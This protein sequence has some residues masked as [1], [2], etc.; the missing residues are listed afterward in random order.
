M[1]VYSISW[2][3]QYV[4]LVL[5]VTI[6]TLVQPCTQVA[7]KSVT[8]ASAS[9]PCVQA[10]CTIVLHD[11]FT[12][13][14]AAK[15]TCIIILTHQLLSSDSSVV[16]KTNEQY[17]KWKELPS[18]RVHL[19]VQCLPCMLC[20]SWSSIYRAVS[21]SGHGLLNQ[22]GTSGSSPAHLHHTCPRCSLLSLHIYSLSLYSSTSILTEIDC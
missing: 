15:S 3:V 13:T 11:K 6:Y 9:I 10:N 16:V 14:N 7:L 20:R 2:Q 19:T 5:A 4:R 18:S 1:S 12:E 22:A 17:I 8:H 21:Q